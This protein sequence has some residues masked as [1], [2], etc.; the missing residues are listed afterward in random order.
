MSVEIIGKADFEVGPNTYQT[1]YKVVGD[2]KSV[3]SD[4]FRER[5][6]FKSYDRSKGMLAG[7]YAASR[8]PKGLRHL[9]VVCAITSVEGGKIPFVEK[10]P[11]ARLRALS[12][13][14]VPGLEIPDADHFFLDATSVTEDVVTSWKCMVENEHIWKTRFGGKFDT[15]PILEIT[16]NLHNWSI[17]DIFPGISCLMLCI[18][19]INED[20]FKAW[21]TV[22]D[23]KWVKIENSLN[24]PMNEGHEQYL[25]TV[26]DFLEAS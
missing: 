25:R 20:R 4:I 15:R 7:Q 14:V 22:P 21:M 17:V 8:S 10:S 23:I 18:S 24:F 3:F 19:G 16:G 1:R 5:N 11:S 6:I 2:L 13:P 12:Q 9:I 26:A